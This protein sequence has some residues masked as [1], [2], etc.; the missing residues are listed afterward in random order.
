MEIS[1][2]AQKNFRFRRFFSSLFLFPSRLSALLAV[3]SAFF[4]I[5]AFPDFELES[6]AFVALSILIVAVE[7]N[8]DSAIKS[9]WLGWLQGAVFFYGTC[10]WLTY[11]PITYGGIPSPIVYL[12][13]VPATLGA[14]FFTGIFAATLSRLFLR[15]DFWAIFTA[16]FLWAACE[17]LRLQITGNA[18]NATGYSQ[19]LDSL[20]SVQLAKYGGVFLVSGFIV[21]FNALVSLGAIAGFAKRFGFNFT[22]CLPIA[23]VVLLVITEPAIKYFLVAPEQ[24]QSPKTVVVA[25]QPN[26][27]MSRLQIDDYYRLRDRHAELAENA[28]EEIENKIEYKD[29][30]R[31]V[32][33]PE[34]PMNF[35][36]A[37][38]SE[39]REFLRDFGARNNVSLVFNGGEPSTLRDGYHNSAVMVN[40]RGEKIAQ[41]DK[42]RLVPFGEYV[43]EFIPG[44]E[45]LPT[46]VGRMKP[47]K[48][49]RLMPFGDVRAGVMICYESAFGDLT[50]QFVLNGAD[51]LV[52]LT[53]DGYGGDTP[54]IRQHL[55]NAVFR[56]VETN[57]PVLRVTNVGTTAYINE[58]G[59]IRDATNDFEIASRVWT[60]SKSNGEETFYVKYG[61]VFAVVCTILSLLFLGLTFLN[62]KKAVQ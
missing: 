28:L 25:L 21:F 17:W 60:I 7:R 22:A 57:R 26:V 52:E 18:W 16:P 38:D 62:R 56:A 10:W 15:F 24:S 44:Q 4:L 53:N 2:T 43:P 30:P 12:L 1:E 61:D 48:D 51:V 6:L 40:A 5:L 59:E 13:L 23:A 3:F 54:I 39:F 49:F 29:L 47:G 33:F 37:N 58:R 11:A 31:I 9:F 46:V 8:K 50:R 14:G 34:S 32:V 42:I 27:P 36:Y 20:G 41:Y 45:F 55:A 35:A 19:A